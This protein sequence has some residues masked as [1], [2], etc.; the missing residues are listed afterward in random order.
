[1][2]TGAPP[3]VL[4]QDEFDLAIEVRGIAGAYR[5]CAAAALMFCAFL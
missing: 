4:L 1:M 5:S 2:P 3:Q